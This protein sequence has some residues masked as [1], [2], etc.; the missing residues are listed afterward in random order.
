[1][2]NVS[3]N[4]VVFHYLSS[5]YIALYAISSYI[6]FSGN[7]KLTC[8]CE[9]AFTITPRQASTDHNDDAVMPGEYLRLCLDAVNACEM[10]YKVTRCWIRAWKSLFFSLSSNVSVHNIE[11]N[12]AVDASVSTQVSWIQVVRTKLVWISFS[13]HFMEEVF[14]STLGVSVR[15]PTTIFLP[16]IRGNRTK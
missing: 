1:M 12:T 4:N 5:T 10:S 11:A 8:P 6:T 14:S 13:V 9:K 16:A 15:L 2:H 7:Y 3:L